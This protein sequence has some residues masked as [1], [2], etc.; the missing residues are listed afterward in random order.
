MPPGES[1]HEGGITQSAVRVCAVDYVISRR[2]GKR[3]A[4]SWDVDHTSWVVTPH[5]P[6][7]H[8]FSGR[9]LEEAVAWCPVWLMAPE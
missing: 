1:E 5:A 7:V 8:D 6:E 3:G 2:T 4:H 9:T